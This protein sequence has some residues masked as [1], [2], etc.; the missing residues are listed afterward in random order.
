MERWGKMVEMMKG[1]KLTISELRLHS[2][3]W[4]R[5][6]P[7]LAALLVFG[8]KERARAVLACDVT[9]GTDKWLVI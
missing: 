7:F 3:P 5:G 4:I 8:P 1:L 2:V 9:I 6:G